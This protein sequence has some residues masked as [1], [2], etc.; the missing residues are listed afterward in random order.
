[1]LR[2]LLVSTL[3]QSDALAVLE[4]EERALTAELG[5][6]RAHLA[7]LAKSEPPT[8]PKVMGLELRARMLAAMLGWIA[9][10]RRRVGS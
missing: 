10:A 2:A 1:M 9:A 4:R 5:P 6:L 7:D 8:D 3:D